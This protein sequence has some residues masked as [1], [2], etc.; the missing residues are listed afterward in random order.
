MATNSKKNKKVRAAYNPFTDY[1]KVG[2][3]YVVTNKAF[4][5]KKQGG[6]YAHGY[7]R[8]K[9]TT[10]GQVG[11]I[12]DAI[13]SRRGPDVMALRIM[14]GQ[15][16]LWLGESDSGCVHN[17]AGN[18]DVAYACTCPQW[19]GSYWRILWNQQVCWLADGEKGYATERK[20]I[21]KYLTRATPESIAAARIVF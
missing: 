1:Y 14:P 8:P 13:S 4:R 21:E 5:P 16:V 20:N 18:K 11:I 19:L 10:G 15:V 2:G 3:L 17:S 7:A 12:V 6:S 9:G